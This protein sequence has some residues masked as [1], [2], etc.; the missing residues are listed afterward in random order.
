MELKSTADSGNN[1]VFGMIAGPAGVGKTTQ[2]S[3]LPVDETIILAVEDGILSIQ[4][5]GHAYAKVNGYD[6]VIDFFETVHEKY[7]WCKYVFIDSLTELFDRVKHNAKGEFTAKQS[8]AKFEDI[9][10]KM[11][12]SIRVASESGL[13]VFFTCHTK[14]EKDGLTLVQELAFDG[15][16]P[17]LVKKLFDLIIHMD[18]ADNNGQKVRV[19]MTSPEVS[20]VAKRRVS[21][22]LGVEVKD[23]E[24]PNIYKLSQ[25]LL[26]KQ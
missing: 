18:F 23:I 20:H 24:E 3:T 22:W 8:Y 11:L 10:D 12:H 9:T 15:K 25:K 16:L 17:A 1:R 21:P 14:E 4:G 2:A 19:F 26:G 5:S 6:D 13:S 7:P